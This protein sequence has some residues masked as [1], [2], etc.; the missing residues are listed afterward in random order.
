M[1]YT[2]TAW[3]VVFGE[4]PSAAKW[5]IIGTNMA[6]FNEWITGARFKVGDFTNSGTSNIVV[7][8]VGFQPTGAIFWPMHADTTTIAYAGFGAGVGSD[9]R[10]SMGRVAASGPN[11]STQSE[12]DAVIMSTTTDGNIQIEGT[13]S[14]FDSDGFTITVSTGSVNRTF[15]YMAF[16]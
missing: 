5:N 11:A 16:K 9:K 12:S 13:L 10:V 2:Y 15:G 8:G 14:S 4:Q 3:S 6:S 1:A 7:T